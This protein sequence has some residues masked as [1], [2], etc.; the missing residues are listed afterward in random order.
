MDQQIQPKVSEENLEGYK[1]MVFRLFKTQGAVET[2]IMHAAIGISGEVA[3]LLA[4]TS[5]ENAVEELGDIEFYLEA[6]KQQLLNNFPYR[7][8]ASNMGSDVVSRPEQFIIRVSGALLDLA[9][10]SWVYKQEVN[11]EKM[12]VAVGDVERA[13]RSVYL[14]ADI[15]ST[16]AR[17][18]NMEKLQKRYP[19]GEY[20]D[21]A[22]QIRADK[23][24]GE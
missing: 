2:D 20:S 22:A 17:Q 14:I 23:A 12:W 24:P 13:L 6:L 8:S 16:E 11:A 15:T 7:R 19:L 21:K 9:K 4:A 1:D 5:R 10:K 3:E 18:S